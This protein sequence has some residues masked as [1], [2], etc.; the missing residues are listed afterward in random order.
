MILYLKL[1]IVLV[2][3]LAFQNCGNEKTVEQRDSLIIYQENQISWVRNFEPLNPVSICRW[4]TRGGIYETLFLGNPVTTEWIPW[5]ATRYE[6]ENNNEKLVFTIRPNVKWSD[7]HPFSAHDVAYTFNLF[8]DYPTLD[9]RNMWE[10]LES[11]S[12]VSDSLVEVN[13]KRL[14]VPGFE[15]L[16]G[17]YIVPKHIWS[18]LEDPLN[19]SNENPVGTGPYTEILRFNSQVWELGKNQNYWQLGKPHVEKLTFPTFSSNEQTTLCLLY[20]SPS[21]RDG[22]LSRMPSSA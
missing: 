12:V 9:T 7:G 10:Y 6:W 19:F 1:I 22:L 20:T 11:V 8:K 21:P 16:A 5:L 13:F 4:P 3:S 17:A 2:A 14:Y 15:A 18:K